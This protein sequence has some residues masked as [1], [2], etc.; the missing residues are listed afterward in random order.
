MGRKIGLI[1][2]KNAGSIQIK[3][4]ELKKEEPIEEKEDK[5][6]NKKVK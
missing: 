3:K 1:Q 2:D 5:K 6:E 4:L